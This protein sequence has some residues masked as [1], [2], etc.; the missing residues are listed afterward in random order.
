MGEYYGYIYKTTN[1]INGKI[2]IG[3]H[4]STCY[5]TN[6]YGSGYAILSAIDKYGI[7]HFDNHIL[8][9]VKNR[10]EANIMEK[11]YIKIYNSLNKKVGYNIALGGDGGNLI[12]GKS[13]AE[14]TM[15]YQK[16]IKTRK[17]KGIGAGSNN[18]MY[19]SGIRGIHPLLGTHLSNET[20]SKISSSLMG[21]TPWNRGLKKIKTQQQIC[22]EKISNYLESKAKPVKSIELNGNSMYFKN[23]AIAERFYNCD[24]RYALKHH[25]KTNKSLRFEYITKE[26][27]LIKNGEL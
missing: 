11:T 15:I 18:P 2:Y 25:S 6:Y 16:M 27:Y 5:D 9:M 22:F 8:C 4:K 13:D 17:T 19:Q 26:E 10:Y 3:Q 21:H 7:N 20:K 23:R 1:L 14:K 24:I 12:E